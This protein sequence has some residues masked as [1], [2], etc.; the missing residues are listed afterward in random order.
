MV[1]GEGIDADVSRTINCADPMRTRDQSCR[2]PR[3]GR[4]YS[5]ANQPTQLITK[6]SAAHG[7]FE[8][9]VSSRAGVY[10]T[11]I[12]VHCDENEGRV[13]LPIDNERASDKIR[14]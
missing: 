11:D 4:R 13:Y 9:V 12:R 2:C 7:S 10:F 6:Y 1:D 8:A 5:A 14:M 3:S